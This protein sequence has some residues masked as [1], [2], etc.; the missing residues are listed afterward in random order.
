MSVNAYK[1]IITLYETPFYKNP[2][3]GVCVVAIAELS[4]VGPQGF[5]LFCFFFLASM[6]EGKRS[7]FLR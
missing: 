2:A 1:F 3:L 7:F 6:L 5:V 4:F